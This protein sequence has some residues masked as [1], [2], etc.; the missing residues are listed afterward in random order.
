MRTREHGRERRLRRRVLGHVPRRAGRQA[1][2]HCQVKRSF[3]AEICATIQSLSYNVSQ[4]SDGCVER[5]ASSGQ[6][7]DRPHMF[8]GAGQEGAW[9]ARPRRPGLRTQTS[10][11]RSCQEP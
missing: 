4:E 5:A 8:A 1:E 10:E 3:G 2:S 7:A 6:T 11:R 9:L